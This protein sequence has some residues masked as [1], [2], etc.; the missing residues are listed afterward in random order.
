VFQFFSAHNK[1]GKRLFKA[2]E[3]EAQLF[4]ITG[5]YPGIGESRKLFDGS[6]RLFRA[7]G[8]GGNQRK[9]IIMPA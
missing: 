3:L 8:I 2:V 5:I 1:R 4:K 7:M 9:N 6:E